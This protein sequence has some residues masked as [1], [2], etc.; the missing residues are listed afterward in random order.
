MAKE[1]VIV[2][3]RNKFPRYDT[4]TT[5]ADLVNDTEKLTK[6]LRFAWIGVDESLP[7]H[8]QFAV[9]ANDKE[10]ANCAVLH[11]LK[12]GIT[13]GLAGLLSRNW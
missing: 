11:E 4:L 13:D 2:I 10:F 7:K 1:T 9:R 3:D 5:W 12:G 6:G 8:E